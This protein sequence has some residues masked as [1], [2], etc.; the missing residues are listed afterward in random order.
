MTKSSQP[1]IDSDALRANLLETAVSEVAIDPSCALLSD[2]V[3]KY[4]G[5]H[6]NLEQLLYEIHHPFRNWTLILPRLRAFVLK[7]FDHYHQH[8]D[9]PEAFGRFCDIFLSAI[10]SPLKQPSGEKETAMEALLAY[11]ERLVSRLDHDGPA[12]YESV[13]AAC[14]SRLVA[15]DDDVT[16]Y[17][18]QSRHCIKKIC[19]LLLKISRQA[20]S[21]NKIGYDLKPAAGLLKKIL[22]LNYRYWLSEEDPLPWFSDQCGEMCQGWEA[23]RLFNRISHQRLKGHSDSLKR[24]EIEA[25]SNGEEPLTLLLELPSHLDIVRLYREVPEKL[26]EAS[27]EDDTGVRFAENRRLLFLF[28]IMDTSGLFLIHEETLREINQAL[29]H[30][31]RVQKFEE[32]ERFLLTAFQL[33]KANVRNYPHTSLQCI[34]I[35]G[36]EIFD[37]GNSRLVET[38]LRET[39]RFGF[40]YA[41]VIGVTRDWQPITNP[42]HLGNIRVW[43]SLIMHEPKWCATLFSALIVNLKL[44][45]TCIKD[46]DLF[47]RHITELLNHPV[48]PVYN[49]VKQFARLMPVFFNEIGAEGVLRDVSTELDEIHKRRDPLIH[50]LRKQSHVESSNLIVEFIEAIFQFWRTKNRDPLTHFLPLEIVTRVATEGEFVD[51]IH[52]LVQRIF[53][54][55]EIDENKDLLKLSNDKMKKFLAEQDDIAQTEV[56]R[57]R[58]LVRMY[59]LVYQK[60]NLGFQELGHELEYGAGTDFPETNGLVKEL[61]ECDTVQRLNILLNRLQGLKEIILS[62]RTF[63]AREDIYHKRHIGVDI[64]SV[65]GCYREKKFDALGLT[66]RLENLARIY[67]EE[68]PRTVNVSFITRATFVRIVKCLRL[69]LRALNIDGI[70]SRRLE[71]QL[72]L[73]SSS[74]G[75]RRFS[76]AQYMD[77]LR[78]FSEG[79]KDVIYT[80]YTNIHQY[81]LS[82]IIP[83]TGFK[84]LLPKYRSM[85]VD[86]DGSRESGSPGDTKS[87]DRISKEQILKLSESVMRDHIAEAFGLRELD[88]FIT[89]IYHTLEEQ[90]EALDPKSLDLLM[91]YNPVKVISFLHKPNPWTHN[92]IHLGNKG[93]NLTLLAY[94]KKPVPPGFVIT[95]EIFR[96]RSV[97]KNFLS[98]HNEFM[99]QMHR[100]VKK[101]ETMTGRGYGDRKNPLLLSVRSGAAISTPGMMATIHNVGLNE[102]LVSGFAQASGK[103]CPAWDNFRRFLQS[104]AMAGG[105]E[106][107]AFQLLM[108][109]AKERYHVRRKS[110]FTPDQMKEL[111]LEYRKEIQGFGIVIPDDPWLQLISA[112]EM[113]FDSWNSSKTREYRDLM[114]LSGSWGTA[115]IVQSMVFGNLGPESGSGV[116]FTA[117]PYRRVRRVA[118]WGDYSDNVHGEDI[119]GGLV[120][121]YP[122][123]EEQAEIDGRSIEFCLEKKFPDI[124]K[125]LLALSRELV[126]E[127]KWNPQE[128]EFT[129]DGCAS[130][131][132]HILQTRDMITMEKMEHLDVFEEAENLDNYMLG[133]GIGV[134][135]GSLS[136]RAVFTI[137]NIRQLRLEDPGTP[138][139]LIRRD[140]VPEDIKAISMA[141]GLLTARGGQTSHASITTLRLKKTCVAGCRSLKIVE[142]EER[143]E[144]NGQTI[145]FRDWVS[146]D[147]IKG[148]F[149]KGAHKIKKPVKEETI[150][151]PKFVHW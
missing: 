11:I 110:R 138:L 45:G 128:I 132:L 38:F 12:G 1:A 34:Q 89:G 98:V 88:N 68:L 4:K 151:T 117:H 69:Y 95:T 64:P 50:F 104:W 30:L 109:S 31:I 144:I 77:I 130:R 146:I 35:A 106:R 121:S 75:V 133:K 124:Y 23:G 24:I 73:L 100:S 21:T 150:Q 25:D 61:H 85:L 72:S 74:L 53:S 10:D 19:A 62:S 105:M 63:K 27:L 22:F 40:Q 41:N 49:L 67:L 57:F 7:N 140:T 20:R 76:F 29:V 16:M 94:E 99:S 46:T 37:R 103:P 127:K 92:L 80:Y 134:Y 44:S 119:V 26:V 51:V 125:P 102:E 129:F 42:A 136:G 108:D 78:G 14:F 120:T 2:I 116:V 28:R 15:L 135:G 9:G 36:T 5:I 82:T 111:A 58:L 139:I 48:E 56:R 143:C 115:V 71:T 131:N 113:V 17:M 147:G 60:Y 148:L 122:I 33:L 149:L 83:Q 54:L 114:G 6:A 84:N 141:D 47:Q 107:D 123:S 18:I 90:K 96:C 79:V 126:Y 87:G 70:T 43:L 145:R 137:K 101:L 13:L 66:F 86:R 32:I 59:R 39:T 55:P 93:Y 142:A 8:R 91:T 81:N 97:V 52:K 3:K 112:V 65:Y 118:L